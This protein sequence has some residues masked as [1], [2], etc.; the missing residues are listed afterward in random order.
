M[1]RDAS[2]L[3][4]RPDWT[5][6]RPVPRFVDDDACSGAPPAPEDDGAHPDELPA[7]RVG[8]QFRDIAIDATSWR[9]GEPRRLVRGLHGAVAPA[10]LTAI[11]G[12]SGSGKT[13][14]LKVL[15][16]REALYGLKATR[17]RRG[18]A[19]GRRRGRSTRPSRRRCPS[20]AR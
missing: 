7:R 3:R 6:N 18:R 4:D 14:L 15:A 11:V 16:G 2:P 20:R 1:R 5:S 19:P 13:T 10:T 17:R 12:P 9:G 8:I